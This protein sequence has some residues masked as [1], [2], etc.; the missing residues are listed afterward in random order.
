MLYKQWNRCVIVTKALRSII[1]RQ[2]QIAINLSSGNSVLP[3]WVCHCS[4]TIITRF[5]SQVESFATHGKILE[6][7]LYSTEHLSLKKSKKIHS[8]YWKTMLPHFYLE[9][10]VIQK[11]INASPRLKK[12]KKLKNCFNGQKHSLTLAI[13]FSTQN[14]ESTTNWHLLILSRVNQK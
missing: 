3:F 2:S 13:M 5:Q 8:S 4:Q 12:K 9:I 6:E 7:R 11:E 14:Y 10:P 1:Q